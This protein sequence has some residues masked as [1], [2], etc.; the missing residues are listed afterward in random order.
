MSKELTT[1]H[2]LVQEAR[3]NPTKNHVEENFNSLPGEVREFSVSERFWI[4]N[5]LAFARGQSNVDRIKLK[6]KED[7]NASGM[8]VLNP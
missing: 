4:N 1:I 7:G 2:Q 5:S 6:K 3:N 8:V